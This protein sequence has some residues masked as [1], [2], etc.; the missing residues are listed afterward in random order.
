MISNLLRDAGYTVLMLGP[1]VPSGDLAECAARHEPQVVCM[2]VTMPDASDRLML[3]VHE[4]ERA[5]HG[6]GYVVGGRGLS[7]RLR[8]R[9]G[10]HVCRRVSEVVQTADAIV[11]R[12]ELN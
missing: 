9:P 8:P 7:A 6:A 1:D 2:T 11:K 5:W 3:A 4:I 12:A 10:I